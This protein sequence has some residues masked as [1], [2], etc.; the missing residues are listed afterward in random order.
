MRLAQGLNRTVLVS[1]PAFFGD[2]AT[3]ACTLVDVE[4]AGLWL[5]CDELKDRLGLAHELSATWTAPV[6]AFF[7]FTQILYIVDPSQFAILARGGPG[8]APPASEPAV[9][10]DVKRERSQRGGRPKQKDS[11]GSSK[12][13]R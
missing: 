12:S 11:K 1:I 9:P 7:P 5:A 10:H 6:T 4:T 8:P 13:R 2:E 3:R